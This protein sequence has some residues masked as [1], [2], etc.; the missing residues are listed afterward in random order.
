MF[1]NYHHHHHVYLSCAGEGGG[2][3]TDTDCCEDLS[4]EAGT[5]RQSSVSGH[6]QSSFFLSP[7]FSWFYL[8]L[9]SPGHLN[10]I[11]T[12]AL[13][14]GVWVINIS[15]IVDIWWLHW[16]EFS[17]RCWGVGSFHW[18]TL[19]IDVPTSREIWPHSGSQHSVWR[20]WQQHWHQ[21]ILS[22]PHCWGELGENNY[23][24]RGEVI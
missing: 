2:C 17:Y 16:W 8:L 23:T 13:L 1:Y 7:F 21:D 4:C 9:L 24:A 3:S 10:I 12:L 11:A 5:C 6:L 22:D 15:R 14:L 20:V 18:P 19:Q